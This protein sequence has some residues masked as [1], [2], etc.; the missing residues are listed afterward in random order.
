M[1]IV[2]RKWYLILGLMIL[3]ILVGACSNGEQ[4][5]GE[6]E[7]K[8]EKKSQTADEEQ[9]TAEN[10]ITMTI[11]YPWDEGQFNERFGPIDEK[12]EN[13]EI[14]YASYDGSSQGLQE[15]FAADVVPDII[16]SSPTNI[17][18]LEELD[19][20]Y[21]LDD[22]VEQENFDVGKL[23]PALV[24]LV[25]GFDS[26][27][28]LIGLPDGTGLFALYYNKEV[29]DLFGMPYPD[30][31][32]PMTWKETLEIAAKMTAERNGQMYIGLEFGGSGSTGEVAQVPLKQLAT[33]MTDRE[34]GEVLI[35]EKS[36]FK[37]YLELM[38]DYYSIPGMRS[39][40]AIEN[41]MFAQKKAAMVINW[42]N[43]L[44]YGWGDLAYQEKMDL[45]PVP[46]WEDKPTTGPYLGT[47]TMVVTTYSKNKLSAFHV[48]EE[49]LSTDNQINI[50]KT[51]ASGPA[52]IEPEV[53][54]EFGSEL[55]QYATRD[56]SVFFALEPATFEKYSHLDRYVN[57]DLQ[58]FAESDADI[59][60]FLRETKEEAEAAIAEAGASN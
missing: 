17:A 36:E 25:K 27:N 50:V 14:K 6:A 45:A 60:T 42:H 33:A 47:A 4:S 34:T 39:K 32:K 44:A 58:K 18:P 43:Y 55:D 1:S 26:D 12:L 57:L 37:S 15:L 10:P 38:K 56:T 2:H 53:L 5:G 54:K 7:K 13:L 31:D 22:L 35:T 59:P 51:M 11:A 8:E 23:N 19:A 16:V 46:V 30:P 20:I 48:L 40:T 24:S 41:E 49:Y 52:V 29:F 28:R 9:G 3:S 21:P